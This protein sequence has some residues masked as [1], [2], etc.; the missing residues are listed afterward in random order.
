MPDMDALLDTWGRRDQP[1]LR[2]ALRR[3]D[4]GD[5]Y[6]SLSDIQV[7]VGLNSSQMRAGVAALESAFPPYMT[8]QLLFGEDP[9]EGHVIGISERARRELGTWP[10]SGD[11]LDRLVAA[12]DGLAEKGI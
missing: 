11:V 3:M 2:S 8:T 12:I 6:I 9:V 7:E 1:I 10:T 5:E 4:A